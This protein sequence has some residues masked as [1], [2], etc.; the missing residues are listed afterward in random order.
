MGEGKLG[1][2][3][4]GVGHSGFIGELYKMFPF[5][6]K[7]EDF[8]QKPEGIEN[9]ERVRAAIEKYGESARI[10]LS[11]DESQQEV[12]I[13]EYRFTRESFHALIKYVWRGGFPQWRNEKRP[14]YVVEFKEKAEAMECWLF[15][16]LF[17]PCHR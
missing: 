9:Q 11:I 5:P 16:G 1:V 12:S 14:D 10:S 4:H 15:E 6:T 13:N 3:I 2:A 7:P 17:F 8:K